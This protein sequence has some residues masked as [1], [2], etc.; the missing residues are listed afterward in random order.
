MFSDFSLFSFLLCYVSV[1]SVTAWT[2]E[3]FVEVVIV[4][5]CSSL[6]YKI[7]F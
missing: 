7:V 5:C 3:K 6:L 2:I 1:I 4:V